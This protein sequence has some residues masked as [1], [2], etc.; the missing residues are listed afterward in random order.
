LIDAALFEATQERL[1]ENRRR[2]RQRRA[3]VRHLLQGLLVCQKCGYAF[4]GRWQARYPRAPG[5][6][7]HYYRCTGMY[8]NGQRRC[9]ARGL[10]VETLDTAV[11]SEVCRLLRDPSRVTQEYQRRLQAIRTG[12]HRP[13]LEAVERQLTKLRTGIGRRI[14]GMRQR[15]AKL[16]AEAA[17]LRAATE[18]ERS[19]HLVINKLETF[20]ELIRSRLDEADWETALEYPA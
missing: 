9:D 5:Y 20:A 11:W 1:A 17:A 15:T 6:G 13:E 14:A 2:H 3:G 16:E 19:L 10:R 7:Y 8:L 4:C 18:Q 12:P